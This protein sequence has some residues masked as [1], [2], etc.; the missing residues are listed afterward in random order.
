MRPDKRERSITPFKTGHET[1]TSDGHR[2]DTQ[3]IKMSMGPCEDVK[4]L[5]VFAGMLDA[6]WRTGVILCGYHS[7]RI[8]FQRNRLR[9]VIH[10]ENHSK[11]TFQMSIQHNDGQLIRKTQLRIVLGARLLRVAWFTTQ[12]ARIKSFRG[13]G[14]FIATADAVHHRP[15]CLSPDKRRFK[16]NRMNVLDVDGDDAKF[17]DFR[18][19][20]TRLSSMHRDGMSTPARRAAEQAW[21]HG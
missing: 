19:V 5:L 1:T 14:F 12:L 17:V 13:R 6:T 20:P 21:A 2:N 7:V 10:G 4:E 9:I 3:P 15:S 8:A 16:R 11:T 18:S